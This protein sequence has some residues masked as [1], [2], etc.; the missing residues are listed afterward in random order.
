M[1]APV[2]WFIT[3]VLAS[4]GLNLPEKQLYLSPV[5]LGSNATN[6]TYPLF[7][8]GFWATVSVDAARASVALSV[9]RTFWQAAAPAV[10]AVAAWPI[11]APQ[12][13]RVVLALDGPFALEQG[14]V[15]DLSGHFETLV[16]RTKRRG[17]VLP[18][19]KP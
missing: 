3:D 13:S 12:S 14:G 9:T 18:P 7:F 8:P 15:L 6:A 16:Q 5:L 2:T 1:T 10:H 17:P 19:D 4:A 11:G